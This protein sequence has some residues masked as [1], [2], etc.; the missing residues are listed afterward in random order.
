SD[1]K[2]KNGRAGLG[3]AG[4]LEIPKSLVN[5]ILNEDKEL[6]EVMDEKTGIAN[7][8]Q[9]MGAIGILTN[10]LIDRQKAYEVMVIYALARFIKPE[11]YVSKQ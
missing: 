5:K 3:C 1:V 9:K 4:A 10:G 2:V 11:F 8:K 7:S 6:G